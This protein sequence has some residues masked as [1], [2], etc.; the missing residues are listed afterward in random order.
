MLSIK[1]LIILIGLFLAGL[2]L[3]HNWRAREAAERMARETCR[4]MG[5]QLLDET[6]GQ[7]KWRV[8]RHEGRWVIRRVFVFEFSRNGAD[9]WPGELTLI[10]G[11]L[12]GVEFNLVDPA[13]E[14]Q[15]APR[16]VSPA[17][18]DD[19]KIVPFRRDS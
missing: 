11:R 13:V 6:V 1:T 19:N 7:K 15:P 5:V 10:G 3:W 12:A 2:T 8:I 9:R 17:S 14:P 16:T 18:P 4:R